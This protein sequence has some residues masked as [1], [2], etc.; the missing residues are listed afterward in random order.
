MPS[1]HVAWAFIVGVA[2]MALARSA[3]VRLV[4]ALYPGIVLF[5]VVVTANHYVLDAVGAVVTVALAS[6]FTAALPRISS[7]LCAGYMGAVS[8]EPPVCGLPPPS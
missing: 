3:L 2:V 1:L 7:R 4:A 8:G 5:V 6:L